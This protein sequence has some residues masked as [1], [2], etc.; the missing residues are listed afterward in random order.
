MNFLA[1]ARSL[2]FIWPSML[3]LLAMLPLL[4]WG[5]ARLVARRRAEASRYASLETAGAAAYAG[6]KRHLPAGLL[7]VAIFAMLAAIARPQANVI[8][9][10]HAETV[11]DL[12]SSSG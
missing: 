12:S 2:D 9:A 5:Y 11:F 1:T 4:G 6:W 8:L 7:L 10:S 3:W